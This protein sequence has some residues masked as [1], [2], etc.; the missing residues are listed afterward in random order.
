MFFIFILYR[1]RQILMMQRHTEYLLFRWLCPHHYIFL[2]GLTAFLSFACGYGISVST[3]KVDA[4]FPYISDTG[5]TVPASSVFGLF[6]N[7]SS[8][9]AAFAIY[10]RHSHME[11]LLDTHRKHIVNDIA[12]FLGILICIGMMMVACFPWT[13]VLVPHLIGALAVFFG[14]NVYCWMQCYISYAVHGTVR[15]LKI[16]IRIILS[17]ISSLGFIFTMVFG[18]IAGKKGQIKPDRLHWQP[19][20]PGYSYH[21]ASTFDEWIMAIAFIA[22]FFTY[23]KEFKS[24]ESEVNVNC[25]T[26]DEFEH[27]QSVA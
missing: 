5:T 10:I 9:F 8:I 17:S 16:I 6:L 22:F 1:R 18:N 15:S 3:G 7:L 21:L 20:D 2:M 14:G 12:M 11:G 27:E 23:F 19:A 13:K 25:R 26:Y 4:L 24:L